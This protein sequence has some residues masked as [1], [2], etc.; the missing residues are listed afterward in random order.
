MFFFS[1][2]TF[3][4]FISFLAP[5]LQFVIQWFS[6]FYYYILLNHNFFSLS[7]DL[8]EITMN[9]D[10]SF[11]FYISDPKIQIWLILSICLSW[12]L[13]NF[14]SS[15]CQ[16]LHKVLKN[17]R[18]NSQH[19]CFR[20][21]IKINSIINGH[22]SVEITVVLIFAILRL[23]KLAQQKDQWTGFMGKACSQSWH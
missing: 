4:M 9:D 18:L 14:I 1:V 6:Y 20:W 16:K 15:W 11:L 3:P 12:K 19:V 7:F 17:R 5:S 13:K 22:M 8:D 2:I 10:F 23:C 21:T